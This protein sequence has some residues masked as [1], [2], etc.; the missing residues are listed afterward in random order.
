[1]STASR[2]ADFYNVADG[3]RSSC[4]YVV[5]TDHDAACSLADELEGRPA[6]GGGPMMRTA[7]SPL[8]TDRLPTD[9][10]S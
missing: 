10:S 9:G 6:A 5:T 8:S 2:V 7:V 4:R 1:V 3:F